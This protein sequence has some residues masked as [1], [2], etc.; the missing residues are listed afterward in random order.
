MTPESQLGGQNR[1]QAEGRRC[2]G[3]FLNAHQSHAEG[4]Q[5]LFVL[6][7]VLSRKRQVAHSVLDVIAEAPVTGW[8]GSSFT[9]D[10]LTQCIAVMGLLAFM[11]LQSLD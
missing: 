11:A 4:R 2:S 1:H 10:A 9:F 3:R 5:Q 6:A 7:G 8:A